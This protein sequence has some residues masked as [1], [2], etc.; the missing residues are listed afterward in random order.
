MAKLLLDIA[1]VDLGAAGEPCAQGMAGVEPDPLGFGQVGA[2][3]RLAAGE[4]DVFAGGMAGPG[5]ADFSCAPQ[6][7]KP[8]LAVACQQ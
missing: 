1:L 2:Q 7:A 3:G 4:D 8:A 5:F 6:F